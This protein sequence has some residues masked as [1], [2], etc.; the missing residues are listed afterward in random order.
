MEEYVKPYI[1]FDNK[2]ST[3]ST[4][5]CEKYLIVKTSLPGDGSYNNKPFVKHLEPNLYLFNIEDVE[6]PIL[7]KSFTTTFP[8]YAINFSYNSNYIIMDNNRDCYIRI[9]HFPTFEYYDLKNIIFS[10]GIAVYCIT[11]DLKLYILT[12][13]NDSEKVIKIYQLNG[14]PIKNLNNKKITEISLSKY[15]IITYRKAHFQ[16]PIFHKDHWWVPFSYYA[17]K[18]NVTYHFPFTKMITHCIDDNILEMYYEQNIIRPLNKNDMCLTYFRFLPYID[19]TNGDRES[20]NISIGSDISGDDVPL[21]YFSKFRFITSYEKI[22]AINRFTTHV[23]EVEIL[24]KPNQHNDIFI[25]MYDTEMKI[26]QIGRYY[27]VVISNIK[28]NGSAY[29]NIQNEMIVMLCRDRKYKF[30]LQYFWKGEMKY[31]MKTYSHTMFSVIRKS[32]KALKIDWKDKTNFELV[33][34]YTEYLDM[35]MKPFRD[36]LVPEDIIYDIIE[37]L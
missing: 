2:I 10:Y 13:N 22:Y 15:D 6:K 28:I 27:P 21:R 9:I 4:S 35:I 18:P 24:D 8:F 16:K 20:D 14:N 31:K 29:G 30:N 23:Y 32:G 3:Y 19:N 11:P 12:R 25:I 37:K 1:G 33:P 17:K 5:Y 26:K 36:I 34:A 7:M